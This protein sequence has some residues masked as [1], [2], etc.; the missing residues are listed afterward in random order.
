[1]SV[2]GC[3]TACRI[4]LW[5][6]ELNC[7]LSHWSQWKHPSGPQEMILPNMY[8]ITRYR[9]CL[10]W[11]V[12]VSC[13]LSTILL[14]CSAMISISPTFVC[15]WWSQTFC[16]TFLSHKNFLHV[17]GCT[18]MHSSHWFWWG[19]SRSI[20]GRTRWRTRYILYYSYA[21]NVSNSNCFLNMEPSLNWTVHFEHFTPCLGY[22][23]DE[24]V[25]HLRAIIS[26]LFYTLAHAILPL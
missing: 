2:I 26:L 25:R 10:N 9:S 1:M 22:L 16:N 11:R 15:Y 3:A 23:D 5:L 7:R 6:I 13:G 8:E 12:N 14:Y 24:M 17:G 20:C 4:C 21:T 18:E 19:G